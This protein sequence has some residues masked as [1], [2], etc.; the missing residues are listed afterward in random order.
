MKRS[1]VF[2]LVAP[3]LFAASVFAQ[4][5]QGMVKVDLGSVASMLATDIKVDV[6][7]IPASVSV[8]VGIAATACDMPAAKLA[9]AGGSEMASCQATS[10]PASLQQLVEKH[11]KESPKQ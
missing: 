4:Q 6:D 7:K 1:H 5:P 3:G 11:V 8:P 9:P 10:T 2:L